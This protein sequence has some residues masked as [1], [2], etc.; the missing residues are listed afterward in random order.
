MKIT[1]K[2]DHGELVVETEDGKGAFI[3]RELQN[4][5]DDLDLQLNSRLLGESVKTT[6]YDKS[7]VPL[8]QDNRGGTIFVT[9]TGFSDLIP[10]P[11]WA[12]NPEPPFVFNTITSVSEVGGKA[13]FN[14][15]GNPNPLV[16]Q[17]VVISGFVN[18]PTYNVT[19]VKVTSASTGQFVIDSIDFV[20]NEMNVGKFRVGSNWRIIATFQ[21]IG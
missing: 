1:S 12:A 16:G 8:P 6:V 4:Y 9:N 10:L 17:R 21:I 3:R 14:F 7:N 18:N 2:P 19:E 11:C 20:G 5:F 15:S 13:Q